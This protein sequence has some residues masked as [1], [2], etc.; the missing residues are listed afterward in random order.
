[1]H[2]GANP[3]PIAFQFRLLCPFYLKSISNSAI[4]V[5]A[6]TFS[7]TPIWAPAEFNPEHLKEHLGETKDFLFGERCRYYTVPDRLLNTWFDDVTA[8]VLDGNAER[9]W[10]KSSKSA[11]RP[12]SRALSIAHAFGIE[13][14][15]IDG[16]IGVL[17]ISFEQPRRS[18]RTE[19][20]DFP[21]TAFSL[22]DLQELIYYSS[23]T[24]FRQAVLRIPS[25]QTDPHLKPDPRAGIDAEFQLNDPLSDRLGRRGQPFTLPEL[26]DFLLAPLL[27][28]I[29][30]FE[31]DQFLCHTTVKFAPQADFASTSLRSRLCQSLAGIA[32][33]EEPD[34][35]PSL[36]PE[37][38]IPHSVISTKHLAGYSYL[39][40]AHFVA[41][42]WGSKFNTQRISIVQGRYFIAF[43]MSLAQ[44]LIAHQFLVR[45]ARAPENEMESIWAEF[46]LFEAAPNPIDVSRREAV[47]R[48][49]R[50]AMSAQRV[51]ET[52]AHLHTIL[53]DRQSEIRVAE[54]SRR[55][56]ALNQLLE[57]QS[58]TQHNLA[59]IE[60]FI[61]TVY[62]A[63]LSNILG[64][65]ARFAAVYR[66][67]G[68]LSFAVLALLLALFH[69]QEARA[70]QPRGIRLPILLGVTL[71]LFLA[72]LLVGF[73]N[74]REVQ[75]P[76]DLQLEVQTHP[77]RPL[78]A[79]LPEG[80]T[81]SS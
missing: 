54:Q 4:P 60:I 25:F 71:A 77:L 73:T 61:V 28:D 30:R 79:S 40:A 41:D 19:E 9:A 14:F 20:V 17:S 5:E 23:Q 58:E 48:C 50:L 35:P 81:L 43:L 8:I 15:L 66:F 10:R 26:R 78:L 80:D 13:L 44:R 37:L 72:W 59:R 69:H 32:Q 12:V 2:T 53:R 18:A 51:A 1:M 36:P 11:G 45:A 76:H 6:P 31:Q 56:S 57:K 34:H 65:T 55:A 52:L 38:G 29:E 70:A 42:Q 62:A 3:H 67:A 68:I 74:F 47:N 63:E 16:R 46:A 75:S 24:Q 7:G 27:Q 33:L 39:G 49:Y 64:E 22:L 21:P